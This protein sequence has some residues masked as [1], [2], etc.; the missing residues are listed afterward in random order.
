L[1]P[2]RASRSPDAE[3]APLGRRELFA[4]RVDYGT[5]LLECRHD[6]A[7]G[8]IQPAADALVALFGSADPRV[9]DALGMLATT[10]MLRGDWPAARPIAQR[11]LDAAEELALRMGVEDDRS[12]GKRIGAQALLAE[13]D[14]ALDRNEE[15]KALLVR[16]R[17]L[18]SARA[19]PVT[20]AELIARLALVE[21]ALGNEPEAARLADE[22]LRVADAGATPPLAAAEVRVR[23][24]EVLVER[25]EFARAALVADRALADRG[26]RAKAGC[27]ARAGRCA[28]GRIRRLLMGEAGVAGARRRS[29][30]VRTSRARCNRR[31]AVGGRRH[32]LSARA[33]RRDR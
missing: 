17:S 18:P 21:W 5:L 19:Q 2:L 13:I 6:E 20:D 33:P 30:G 24:A 1:P 22:A 15:A 31:V 14:L 10:E 27:R 23:V 29:V 4:E 3:G 16:A 8:E 25:R 26:R 9:V 28:R 11:A 32:P 12:R 7:K